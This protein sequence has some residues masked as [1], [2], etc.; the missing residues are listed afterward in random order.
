MA[1]EKREE[2]KKRIKYWIL[3]SKIDEY[4]IVPLSEAQV[5][6]ILRMAAAEFPVAHLNTI[7]DYVSEMQVEYINAM[8]TAIF[9]FIA[10]T[11]AD[12]DKFSHVD[13][14][15]LPAPKPKAPP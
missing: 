4:E 3:V 8:K 9:E 14:P 12:K 2:A 5:D 11:S 10:E 13:L 7:R 1:K 6:S 15:E